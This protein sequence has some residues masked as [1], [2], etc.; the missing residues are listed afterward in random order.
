MS[1]TQD[2]GTNSS[3]TTCSKS[4]IPFLTRHKRIVAFKRSLFSAEK[5]SDVLC[6]WRLKAGLSSLGH[7]EIPIQFMKRCYFN[8]S[9]LAYCYR[10]SELQLAST[11]S[12]VLELSS[13]PSSF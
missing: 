1:V 5:S 10:D 6:K 11:A 9:N 3:I 13:A 7:R 12:F 8:T 2:S 4:Q